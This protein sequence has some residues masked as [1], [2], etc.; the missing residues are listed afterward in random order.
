MKDLKTVHQA[1]FERLREAILTGYFRPGQRLVERE[2]AEAM[3]ISRTPI[4]EALRKLE[5]EKLVTNIPY[6][7]VFVSEVSAK[8][9]REVYQ[10]RMV[11]E[12]LATALAAA[13]A[14]PQDLALLR[15]IMEDLEKAV[16]EGRLEQVIEGNKRFHTAI[17]EIAG[18]E[19]LRDVLRGL[20]AHVSLLRVTSLSQPG[21]PEAT[22]KE[23]RAIYEAIAAGD[24]EQAE[25]LA[26]DH[27]RRAGEAAQRQ[28]E[29]GL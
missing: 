1:V 6:R 2:L 10:V 16:A 3:Q 24:P 23:H 29:E 28:L 27:V 14:T 22:L 26:A 18:N 15:G 7:G 17:A 13:R 4:R 8:T 20:Q 25:K 5:K 19:V 9:A 12:G 21:R 11:L